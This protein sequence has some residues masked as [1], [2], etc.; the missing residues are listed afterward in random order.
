MGV[1]VVIDGYNMI[2]TGSAG[3]SDLEA[4][5]EE[6]AGLLT[7]YKKAKA[8]T[9]TVVFDAHHAPVAGERSGRIKGIPVVYSPAG[10][11]ADT[12]IAEM[13][14]RLGPKAVVVTSDRGLQ[15]RVSQAG[16]AFISCADFS[17]K[18][19]EALY[20]SMGKADD[21]G[22]KGPVKE[23]DRKKGPARRLTKARRTLL[24]KR[25]KL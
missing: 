16:A 13:A 22:D 2:F 15:I 12:V 21:T 23:A 1:H 5:R 18:L 10:K 3:T 19:D 7:L 9:V 11:T 20:E 6:L 25:E 8:H 4:A 17:V 24:K 14:K